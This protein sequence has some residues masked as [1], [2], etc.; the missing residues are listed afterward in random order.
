MHMRAS[1]SAHENTFTNNRILFNIK[2]RN[3]E[4]STENKKKRKSNR[5]IKNA[6]N[7]YKEI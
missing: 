2:C 3:R 6:L 1:L 5:I 7:K 4:R